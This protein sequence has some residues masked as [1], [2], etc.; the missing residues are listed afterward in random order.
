MSSIC[1]ITHSK[2]G[3]I[4]KEGRNW[5]NIMINSQQGRKEG[6]LRKAGRQ[7]GKKE[8]RKEGRKAGRQEGKKE[9]RK[10]GRKEG[11]RLTR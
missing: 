6:F 1:N 7:E 10:E 2:E 8:G 11:S 4:P 3:R 9:G 5:C